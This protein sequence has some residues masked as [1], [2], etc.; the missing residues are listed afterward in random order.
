MKFREQR[1]EQGDAKE[2]QRQEGQGLLSG[3]RVE[4]SCTL[5]LE[6]SGP[7]TRTRYI[8]LDGTETI[9]EW[10]ERDHAMYAEAYQLWQRWKDHLFDG[11]GRFPK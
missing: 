4:R 8:D 2:G 7:L 10:R 1:K 9:S 11:M 3:P 5:V 6:R